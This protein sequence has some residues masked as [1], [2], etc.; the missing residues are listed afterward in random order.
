MP[1]CNLNDDDLCYE[2]LIKNKF[3]VNNNSDN[4][5]IDIIKNKIENNE[6]DS[7]F[8]QENNKLISCS[9]DSLIK[10]WDINL[11]ILILNRQE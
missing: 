4:N 8:I 3:Y 5:I 10:I 11:L 2:D 9:S 7:L 1:G 6:I